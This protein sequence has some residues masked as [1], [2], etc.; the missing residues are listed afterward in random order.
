MDYIRSRFRE[1]EEAFSPADL[2][3]AYSVKANGNLAL[4]NRLSALGSGADIVSGGELFRALNGG[5]TPGKIV[6]AGVGKTDDELK[7]G[8]DARI[9]AFNVETTDELHRLDEFAAERGGRAP[10]GVRI[11]PDIAAP[12]PH[13]YTRTGH[14]AAK[15][16]LPVPGL[17]HGPTSRSGGSMSTSALRSWIQLPTSVPSDRSWKWSTC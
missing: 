3:L 15:F 7:A 9:Y 16:G 10:F 6:F 12:T 5:I 11:N 14:A 4:L 1:L 8:L 17:P 2:L 13:E